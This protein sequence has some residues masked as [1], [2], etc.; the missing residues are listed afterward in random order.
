MSGLGFTGGPLA[1]SENP[2][3]SP[4]SPLAPAVGESDLDWKLAIII[5]SS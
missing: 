5:G 2:P 3:R 4:K 1:N